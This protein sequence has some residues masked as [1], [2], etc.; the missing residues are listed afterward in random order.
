MGLE[1]DREEFAPEDFDL[2]SDRLDRSLGVLE[3]LL[4]RPDFGIGPRSLGAE[5]EMALVDSQS[6]A[7]PLNEEVLCETLDDRMTVELDRFN[8]ECNLRHVDLAGRPFAHLRS[9]IDSAV[10]ELSRAAALHGGRIAMIGIL[11]TVVRSDLEADALTDAVRY[12]ALARSLREQRKG[13][14]RLNI[15]GDDPLA[16]ECEDVTFEGAATSFQV[17]L[18]VDPREFASTFNA[19]QFA[20]APLL[21]AAGNSLTFLG[22]RLWEET[23]IA[24]F[25]QAVD[26]RIEDD[27]IARRKPRVN[28][29]SQW[30]HDGAIELFREAQRDYSVL[31]PV[32]YDEDPE[33]AVRA[34]QIPA[35][36]EI[37]LHQ[38]T[39]WHWNRPVY[40]PHDSGHVRMEFRV[41]PSGPT[42]QDMLANSAFLV[43][44]A[45]GLAPR[46]EEIASTFEFDSAHHNFYRAGQ[47]GLEARLEWPAALVGNTRAAPLR[48]HAVALGEVARTGLRDAGVDPE[49]S[50][51]LID[52]MLERIDRGQ[53]GSVWQRRR[54][55]SLGS[56]KPN[57]EALAL[58]L[59]EYLERSDGGEPVHEWGLS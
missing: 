27:R 46:F 5:L 47:S 24:L 12:R 53:T 17:H 9:E 19:A 15:S 59:E 41:L 16:L 58:M 39:V 22:H 11:P 32:V 6:R 34:G 51:P 2:F 40:D 52:C 37:R 28:F 30:L 44:L 29:G 31:L 20:T 36:K 33:A 13:P 4:E 7:L 42:P 35:L 18:R 10:S 48:T 56:G 43:G 25:K 54:L 38:G 57:R 26:E 3:E 45:L 55:A 23:R 21:A 49:D 8:L 50:D 14:F 1:I